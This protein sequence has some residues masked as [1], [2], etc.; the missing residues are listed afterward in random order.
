M[1]I[2]QYHLNRNLIAYES[3]RKKKVAETVKR[4]AKPGQFL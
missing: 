4:N 1:E 3:H 2:A